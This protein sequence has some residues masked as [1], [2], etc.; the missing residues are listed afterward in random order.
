M[1]RETTRIHG[2]VLA[3]VAAALLTVPG[4]PAAQSPAPSNADHK[5]AAVPLADAPAI[6]RNIDLNAA[7]EFGYAFFQQK[8]L[9]CHGNP[10]YEKAPPPA[11]L[12][13][14][15]PER[16]YESLATG[17]MASVVGNQLSDAEKKAVAETITGR[18]IGTAGS[19]DADKM[20]NRCTSNPPLD[21]AARR[22]AW[23]GW[24]ADA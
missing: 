14:Y 8:C 19:G 24:G 11:T 2:F 18:R 22:P 23:N 10:Q 1:R 17:V 12:Y 16:I 21:K 6:P 9:T 15:T 20:P 13:Q 4:T 3:N 5:N 7:T